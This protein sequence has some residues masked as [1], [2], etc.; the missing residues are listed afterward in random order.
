[1]TGLSCIAVNKSAVLCLSLI[2]LL[3]LLTERDA[4]C[5]KQSRTTTLVDSSRQASLRRLVKQEMLHYLM[6]EKKDG[7]LYSCCWADAL[8]AGGVKGILGVFEG[9]L[10]MPS[11][12]DLPSLCE[13][14]FLSWGSDDIE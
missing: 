6:A 3:L 11:L 8:T 10:D 1:M 9:L 7:F 13:R 4:R 12:L 14:A 2:F 5:S